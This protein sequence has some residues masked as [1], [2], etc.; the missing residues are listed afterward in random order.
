MPDMLMACLD[1]GLSGMS[2]MSDVN[3]PH[4]QGM[5]YTPS[6]CRARS[7]LNGRVKLE[8]FLGGWPTVLMLC[9]DSTLLMW[10]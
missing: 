5:V 6:V 4:L 10:L 7:S 1:P 3:C 8:T 2:D 9:L